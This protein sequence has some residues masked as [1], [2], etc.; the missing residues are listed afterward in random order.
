M[1]N[2]RATK[3][4]F[5]QLDWCIAFRDTISHHQKTFKALE[6]AKKLRSEEARKD[7]YKG[8][9]R[10]LVNEYLALE[11]NLFVRNWLLS[12]LYIFAPWDEVRM[13]ERV[14]RFALLLVRNAIISPVWR[15]GLWYC[16]LVIQSQEWDI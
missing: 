3:R 6:H 5:A 4:L 1:Q 13:S 7:H 12:K 16:M 10:S 15:L 2:Y 11:R 9:M 14:E 8:V